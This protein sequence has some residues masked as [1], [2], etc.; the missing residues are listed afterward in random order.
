MSTE[1]LKATWTILQP[2]LKAQLQCSPE[3][4]ML[5]ELQHSLVLDKHIPEK[6]EEFQPL[7]LVTSGSLTAEFK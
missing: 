4:Q 1:H 2:S 7:S 3:R 6:Q 5:K